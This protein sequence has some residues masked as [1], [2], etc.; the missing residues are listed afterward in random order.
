[1]IGGKKS[2]ILV[3]LRSQI[4]SIELSESIIVLIG[5]MVHEGALK[6]PENFGQNNYKAAF[7]Q[8]RF[9]GG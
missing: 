7:G 3:G 1:V 4:V 6:N 9:T 5:E 2:I 8:G